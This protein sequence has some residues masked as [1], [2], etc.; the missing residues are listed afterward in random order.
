MKREVK[1]ER[2]RRLR[3]KREWRPKPARTGGSG[4][5][6]TCSVNTKVYIQPF[7]VNFLLY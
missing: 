4:N 3:D 6:E 1:K 7:E 2:Q 5:F